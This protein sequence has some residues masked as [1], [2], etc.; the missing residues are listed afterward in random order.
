MIALLLT[1]SCPS[2][3]MQNTS[4]YP[5]NAYDT[6]RMKY[7]ENRCVKIY[8]D[9]PCLKLWKKWGKTDYSAICGGPN[10]KT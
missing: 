10:E 9:S 7:A 1:L 2:P 3:V 6:D 5:W 4:G 8:P